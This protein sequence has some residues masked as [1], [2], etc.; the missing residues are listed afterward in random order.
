MDLPPDYQ[1]SNR[2]TNS[3]DII[4]F[5]CFLKT[6]NSPEFSLDLNEVDDPILSFITAIHRLNLTT[7]LSYS[8]L[9]NWSVDDEIKSLE[10]IK[11]LNGDIKVNVSIDKAH[12]GG[13]TFF[14]SLIKLS[15]Y[16]TTLT[17]TNSDPSRLPDAKAFS[18]MFFSFLKR[19]EAL[20]FQKCAY[21]ANNPLLRRQIAFHIATQPNLSVTYDNTSAAYDYQGFN[22]LPIEILRAIDDKLRTYEDSCRFSAVNHS[23]FASEIRPR[24]LLIKVM[25]AISQGNEDAITFFLTQYPELS[26]TKINYNSE[27]QGKKFKS[28]SPFKYALYNLDSF[29]CQAIVNAVGSQSRRAL[30][31]A[32]KSVLKEQLG[33]PNFHFDYERLHTELSS[34]TKG[35]A[36]KSLPAHLLQ[37]WFDLTIPFDKQLRPS[38]IAV[39]RNRIS[40]DSVLWRTNDILEST[41]GYPQDNVN[42]IRAHCEKHKAFIQYHLMAQ[43]DGYI[44]AIDNR[45]HQ[46]EKK[47]APRP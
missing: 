9:R 47:F 3:I 15:P 14:K 31:L 46:V 30:L 20:C 19:C 10:R 42:Y 36:Q 41:K 40:S 16:I 12:F 44:A 13:D 29:M 34:S 21:S 2:I 25:D 27:N 39:D 43:I 37:R 22:E 28:F 5:I 6:H 17:L 11:K 1:P 7:N 4:D 26:L 24:S 38:R 35:L 8:P 33:K 45:H 18:A 23:L 32:L